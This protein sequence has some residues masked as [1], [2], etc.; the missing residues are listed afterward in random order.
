MSLELTPVS[1]Q[2][3]NPAVSYQVSAG[4]GGAKVHSGLLRYWCT[5]E[6]LWD[7]VN[8]V[9][10]IGAACIKLDA[11]RPSLGCGHRCLNWDQKR[12][13]DM[14]CPRPHSPCTLNGFPRWLLWV[15]GDHRHTGPG[16]AGLTEILLFSLSW[17]SCQT[18]ILKSAR[19]KELL[20]LGKSL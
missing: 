19:E 15:P 2:L 18:K 6:A 12:V 17:S 14:V 13:E 20:E 5:W 11:I 16:T 10:M 4:V 7:C 8:G 9:Q 1:E 3:R